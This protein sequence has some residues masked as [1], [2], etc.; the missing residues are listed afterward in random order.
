M[1]AAAKSSALP[2]P[3][4]T[5]SVK[6]CARSAALR[7]PSGRWY[8]PAGRWRLSR[9]AALEVGVLS[10][11]AD[12]SAES[13]FATLGVRENMTVQVLGGFAAG[14]LISAAKE[15]RAALSLVEK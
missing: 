11:S 9:R 10:L 14:G 8:A 12:R 3:K 1:F 6:R 4:A 15:E 13:I 5:A 7:E 2:A